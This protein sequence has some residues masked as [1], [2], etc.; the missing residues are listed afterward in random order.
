LRRDSP[1]AR[2]QQAQRLGD[3]RKILGIPMMRGNVSISVVLLAR[4]DVR[5]RI[6]LMTIY[7]LWA[8][9]GI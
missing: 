3:Y 9:G 2:L 5:Q 1:R 8:F 7:R 4:S 6:E